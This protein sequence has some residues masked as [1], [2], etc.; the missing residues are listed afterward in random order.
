[1]PSFKGQLIDQADRRR[2]RLRRRRRPA[3]TRTADRA[4]LPDDF[5]RDVR[6]VATDFDRTLVWKDGDAAP[7]HDRGAAAGPRRRPAGDRRD[8]PDGAVGAPGARAGRARRAG[9]LLPGRGRR[10]RG[11]PLAAARADPARARARD[12]RRARGRGLLAER[13]RRRRALR[14]DRHGG[15]A[16]VRGLSNRSTSTSSATLLDWLAEPPTKL[17]CVG[18]PAAL[19]GLEPRMKER[20]GDRAHISKSLPHFLEFARPA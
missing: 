3:A 20:F 8:R 18:D 5:P 19:D 6:V 1:M 17:V 14:R 4:P 2:H 9:D 16:R 7:A 12:D 10:R 13:L 15:G 11:R